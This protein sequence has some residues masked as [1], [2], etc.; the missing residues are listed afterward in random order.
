VARAPFWRDPWSDM[1]RYA[2]ECYSSFACY[3]AID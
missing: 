2:A 1:R 3:L